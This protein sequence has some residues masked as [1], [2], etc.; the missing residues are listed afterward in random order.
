M[1]ATYINLDPI[2]QSIRSFGSGLANNALK[3]A[4]LDRQYAQDMVAFD[5]AQAD[6]DYTNAKKVREDEEH[7]W[8]KTLVGGYDPNTLN[9]QQR[10]TIAVNTMAG[11]NVVNDAIEAA[12]TMLN[13]GGSGGEG[14]YKPLNMNAIEQ[15]FVK[16]DEKGQVMIDP[17]TGR[18]VVDSDAISRAALALTNMNIPVTT[19]SMQ[20]YGMGLIKPPSAPVQPSPQPVATNLPTQAANQPKVGPIDIPSMHD[21]IVQMYRLGDISYEQAVELGKQF[22]VPL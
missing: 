2:A 15:F 16:K 7:G 1:S 18:P 5:K 14:G 17:M 6:I 21:V 10:T 22:G 20:H 4:Q 8:K 9:P 3:K 19:G 11:R 12:K 13:P